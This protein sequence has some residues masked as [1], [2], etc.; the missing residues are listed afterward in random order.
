MNEQQAN[1]NMRNIDA[2]I[3]LLESEG[4][5]LWMQKKKIKDRLEEIEK[6][7]AKL[8]EMKQELAQEL[9]E[10]KKEEQNIE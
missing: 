5:K 9:N 4:Y 10:N 7:R 6:T 2:K 8:Y 1:D 3:L